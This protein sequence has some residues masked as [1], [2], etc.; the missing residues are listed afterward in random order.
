MKTVVLGRDLNSLTRYLPLPPEP[1]RYLILRESEAGL[2][3]R[4]YL[5]RRG[6]A[7]EMPRATLLRE[8]SERFR[9]QYVHALG[10]LNVENASRE[11]WAMPFTTKNPIS[12]ELCRDAFAFLLIVDLVKETDGVLVVVTESEALAAQI[13]AWG[14]TANVAVKNTVKPAWTVRRLVSRLAPLATVLLAV[15]ALWFRVRLGRQVAERVAKVENPTVIVT[16]VH[17]HSITVDGR[18]RDTYFG[19]LSEWLA[20]RNVPVVVAGIVQGQ[21]VSLA[22]AFLAGTT[23]GT[24]LPIEAVLTPSDILRCGWE[25]LRA[26]HIWSVRAASRA[27][28]LQVGGVSVTPLITHAIREAHASGDV[29][30]SF[31][32]YHCA[33]R[34][35]ECMLMTRCIYP[36]ENR[37]WE[38]MLLLGVRASSPGVHM[39]GYQHASITASHTN[40]VLAEKEGSV[41]PLPDAIVTMGEVTRDWLVREGHYPQALVRGGCA[42]RQPR[43]GASAP[44]KER[45]P[46]VVRV[47][48]ALATSLTEY[49]RTLA[50]LQE[51]LGESRGWEI[52]I[53]PHPT[54]RL[55]DAIRFLPEGDFRLRYTTSTGSVAEDLAW[56]DVVLYASSTIGLEAV[57][58]GIP[59]VYLDLGDILDTDP[60]GGWTE[61][62]WVARQPKDLGLV[63]SE[64]EALSNSEYEERQRRGRAYT[65]AYFYP[66]SDRTLQ[67]F[68]EA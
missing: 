6:Y 20:S 15:R 59:A 36:Y 10:R 39:V 53:R 23:A 45:S 68:C 4:D 29:F 31:Y 17:P 21:S 65:D 67:V 63:F 62:K 18:F 66:V 35:G 28:Q 2:Q 47:L 7:Q 37:A 14:R 25:A 5:A 42:L 61:F 48:V 40:F 24:P 22:R 34:V 11:W 46:R 3:I 57:G 16:L 55:A 52:R 1:V 32:V 54:L 43:T 30:R 38:K 58:A 13:E 44:L 8:R 27:V 50:F 56:A 41:T 12:T 19:G 64:I 51:S 26:F 9:A 60:M 33:R 49:V